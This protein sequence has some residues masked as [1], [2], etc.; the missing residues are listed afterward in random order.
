VI[1]QSSINAENP[2]TSF[3]K[4]QAQCYDALGFDPGLGASSMATSPSIFVLV[5]PT[6]IASVEQITLHGHY[7]HYADVAEA[8]RDGIFNTISRSQN[9]SGS[10]AASVSSIVRLYCRE[11]VPALPAFTLNSRAE[12]KAVSVM[13]P[14]K[15]TS[16]DDSPRVQAQMAG[17]PALLSTEW[18]RI[19]QYLGH[20]SNG[21]YLVLYVR[22]YV[23]DESVVKECPTWDIWPAYLTILYEGLNLQIAQEMC[24]FANLRAREAH[25]ANSNNTVHSNDKAFLLYFP[26]SDI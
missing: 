23:P 6:R 20:H 2:E 3:L 15:Y 1:L 19:N 17:A 10:P 4:L 5:Y 7:F 24:N 11:T 12:T 26:P 25:L 16:F 22:K 14:V 9:E 18:L 21:V 8:Y 13:S